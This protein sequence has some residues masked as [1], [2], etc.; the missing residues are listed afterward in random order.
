MR[1]LRFFSSSRNPSSWCHSSK[2]VIEKYLNHGTS[3]TYNSFLQRWWF[4]RMIRWNQQMPH[5][6]SALNHRW[7]EISR[8]W[9][10]RRKISGQMPVTWFS[11][12]PL[13]NLLHGKIW[14]STVKVPSLARSLITLGPQG[15][16]RRANARIL[17]K[18]HQA[19]LPWAREIACPSRN[20]A[21]LRIS[22]HAS[23]G[24]E[25]REEKKSWMRKRTREI[26]GEVQAAGTGRKNSDPSM[27]YSSSFPKPKSK[28]TSTMKMK[29]N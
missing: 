9:I 8:I 22:V 5:S 25:A 18:Y 10:Y 14:T 13:G 19:D 6:Q 29:M 7:T 20:R 4:L 15:T 17:A 21:S 28:M 16:C 3:P 1:S 24:A 11:L 12:C 26:Q 23:S 27:A 2:T